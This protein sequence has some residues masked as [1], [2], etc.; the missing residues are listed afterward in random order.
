MM[1]LC[2]LVY[3]IWQSCFLGGF[4]SL[5]RWNWLCFDGFLEVLGEANVWR[6]SAAYLRMVSFYPCLGTGF[7]GISFVRIIAR[8]TSVLQ[9]AVEG[10]WLL[11]TLLNMQ[12]LVISVVS[13][14]GGKPTTKL[15]KATV[16][17]DNC[18]WDKSF[19]ESVK[20]GSG[21][22]GLVGEASID[23]SAYAEAIKT[24]TVSLPLKNSNSKAILNVSIQRLQENADK[25]ELEVIEDASIKS[26]DRSLKAHLSNDDADESNKNDTVEDVPFSK[27]PH[28]V[29]LHGNNRGSNGLDITSSSSDSSSGFDTPRE[30]GNGMRNDSIHQDP[31]TYLSSKTNTST[32]PKPTPV[33]S[34]TIYDEWSAGSDHGMSTDGSNSSQNTFPG[35]NSQHGSDNEIEKLKNELIALS[36]QVD[37]SDLEMQTLRKQIVMECKRGQDLSRE[38]VALKEERDALKLE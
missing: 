32:T 28:N 27:T 24:S 2:I 16:L 1:L 35:E 34:T 12:T 6:D 7:C 38:V 26:Q 23:F 15:E 20:Y 14:D 21:K 17:D 3:W 19:Y 29:E 33:A 30:L 5:L 25:I 37:V 22:G 4:V 8:D 31:P 36:R 13:G 11:V 18:R 10:S 9:M